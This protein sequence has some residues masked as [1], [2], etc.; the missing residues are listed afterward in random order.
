MPP[1]PPRW[2]A[3]RASV[4]NFL[5][6]SAPPPPPPPQIDDLPPPMSGLY[7]WLAS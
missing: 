7:V 6:H 1:D 5:L 2:H 3:L 4:V